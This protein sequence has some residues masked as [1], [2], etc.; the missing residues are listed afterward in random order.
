MR[1]LPGTLLTFALTAVCALATAEPAK[2]GVGDVIAVNVLLEPDQEASASAARINGVLR[3][4][5][6]G[7]FALDE[8]H[9]PHISVLHGYV[10]AKDLTEIYRAV[11]KVSADHPLVGQQLTVLGLE[12]K[13]WNGEE[14]TNIKLAKTGELEAFQADLVSA[15]SPH[16]VERGDEHAF[17]TSKEDPGVDRETLEYVRTFVQ[18]HTGT[19]FEPHIT[20]GISDAETA[21]QVSAQQGAPTKLTIAAV[22]VFQLGNVGTARKELWRDSR[23]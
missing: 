12:H 8:S 3:R 13:P 21:R 19:R 1:L 17:L 10:Q 14:I 2:Q 18:K 9:R 6:P 20:V 7:G 22:A 4:S 16:L 15:V 5:D 11:E 23:R